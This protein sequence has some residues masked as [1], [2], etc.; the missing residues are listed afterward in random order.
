MSHGQD[1]IQREIEVQRA[2][3]L[4]LLRIDRPERWLRDDL[5]QE[6]GYIDRRCVRRAVQRLEELG[7]VEAAGEA[8]HASRAARRLDELGLIGV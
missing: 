2:V 5:E 4:Q 1:E 8:R 6:L 3:V 7:V